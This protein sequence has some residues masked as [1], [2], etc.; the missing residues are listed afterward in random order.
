MKQ[1]D[2]EKA[3]KQA[4]KQAERQAKEDERAR[5]KVEQSIENVRRYEEQRNSADARAKEERSRKSDV[6]AGRK[7]EVAERALSAEEKRN[8]EIEKMHDFYDASVDKQGNL[9]ISINQYK[10]VDRLRKLGFYRYDQPGG[11]F[12]Y[13]R[14]HGGKIHLIGNTTDDIQQIID[15]FEDYVSKLP[16]RTVTLDQS[17]GTEI[18]QF[19]HTIYPQL[20]LE[21]IYR[22]IST[23]FNPTLP[24]L[25]PREDTEVKSISTVHDTKQAKYFFFNNTVVRVTTAGTELIPYDK[26]HD[27]MTE[28]CEDNGYYIWDS[29]IIDRDFQYFPD[30]PAGDFEQLCHYVCGA[31]SDLSEDDV[32][33]RLQCL[34]SI[35]GYMMHDN[36]E[37]NNK[38]ALF[39]DAKIEDGMSSG[40]TGKGIIGKALRAMTNRVST[41]TKYISIPGKGLDTKKDTR[42]STG[43]ITTQIIHIEDADRNINFED[44]YPDVTEGA[45]F[46]KLH[47][48]PTKH[49]CKIM[50]STNCPFNINAESTKR[51]IVLFEL[52]PYFSSKRTPEMVFGRRLFEGDWKFGEWLQFD[53]F[54]I[55]CEELYMREGLIQT[56]ELNY[57]DNFLMSELGSDVYHW[58]G[59]TF[60][61]ATAEQEQKCYKM[62]NLWDMFTKKY[63]DR[64]HVRNSF[65]KAIKLYL[66]TKKIPS[67]VLRSTED[68][69][70]L[71]PA[72]ATKLTDVI[73]ES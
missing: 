17:Y 60:V 73:F 12:E 65:T 67:G 24:R 68:M 26:I 2:E 29:S 32:R 16:E 61:T 43:D 66:R 31:D 10:M 58:F 54:M 3:A 21:K 19:E 33:K 47:H 35:L 23:Y 25:R 42:Y 71:Y 56:G 57:I 39:I 59:T 40:G 5:K 52:S 41:D 34:M 6:S 51:R 55:R 36:Y 53:N 72:K 13:V 18:A 4:A 64:Y 1:T 38:L 37:C 50:I 7:K 15:A 9:V 8:L 14:I 44:L 48:D 28:Y 63:P 20:L 22:G 11:G 70:I 46:R 27:K 45:T 62:D 49:F 69:L 30:L